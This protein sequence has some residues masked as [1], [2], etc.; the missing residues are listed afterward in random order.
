LRGLIE[1]LLEH[2]RVTDD[3]LLDSHELE[4]LKKAHG[5]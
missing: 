2:R 1:K 3:P 5:L 4:C